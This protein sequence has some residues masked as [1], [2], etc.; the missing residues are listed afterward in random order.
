[1]I[2]EASVPGAPNERTDAWPSNPDL[3]EMLAGHLAGQ[4]ALHED[5]V[6]FLLEPAEI[7]PLDD[8]PVLIVRISP[9]RAGGTV[10]GVGD[11]AKA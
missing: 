9:R 4:G 11:R 3:E 7:V 5:R 8:G 10:R 6:C 2:S 1:M